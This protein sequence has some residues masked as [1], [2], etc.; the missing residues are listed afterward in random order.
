MLLH[1]H[2]NN[3]LLRPLDTRRHEHLR[4]ARLI[5]GHCVLDDGKVNEG[6]LEYVVGEVAF[7]NAF[8]KG[9]LDKFDLG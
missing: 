4:E 2:D 3:V 6:N 8:P 5:Y 9:L 7:E 1:G